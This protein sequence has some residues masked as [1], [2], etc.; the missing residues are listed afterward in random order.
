MCEFGAGAGYEHSVQT[1]ARAHH[2][3]CDSWYTEFILEKSRS[4]VKQ[5]QSGYYTEGFFGN[6]WKML[7][8]IMN[9]H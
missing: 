3:D 7:A 5:A 2:F 9:C 1:N 6:F 4:S 8:M